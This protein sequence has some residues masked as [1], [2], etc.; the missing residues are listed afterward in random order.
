M[1]NQKIYS[2]EEVSA[3]LKN[4]FNQ[5]EFAASTCANKYL[6]R[7]K[8][9]NFLECSLEQ[10]LNR[11]TGVL[12]DNLPPPSPE[13]L[14]THNLPLSS[15]W[16]DI[17]YNSCNKLKG[18]CP[19][20]SIL[21]GAGDYYSYKSLSN[22]FVIAPPHDSI[23]GIN[24]SAQEEALIMQRRGGVGLDISTL[25]P[26]GLSVTNAAK[27]SSGAAGWMN[28]FS[29][30]CK[31]IGH[32]GRRGALMITLDVKHP[33][34]LL[35][36]QSK[37]DLK[38]CTGANVSVKISD[39]FMKAVKADK[40]F[41]QQFPIDSDKPIFSQ[42]IKARELWA[43]IIKSAHQCA[44]PGLIFWDN[45]I[46]NLPANCYEYFKSSSTNPCSELILSNYDSCR[47]TTICLTN[48]INDPF[49]K[50]PTFDFNKFKFDVRVAMRMMDAVINEEIKCID[51]IIE[52][53]LKDKKECPAPEIYDIELKLWNKIRKAAHDGR[54]TGLGTHALGDCLLKL[55]LKYDTSK[56]LE[57]VNEIYKTLM[58]TAYDESVEMGKEYGIFPAFDWEL[59]KNC[60]FIKRLP[61]NLQNKIK[62]HGRRNISLLTCAPTGTIS[63]L[64]QTS[65]GIEPIFR[66]MYIRRRKINNN[67]IDA[68]VDFIDDLGDRWQE[69]QIF[70]HAVKEYLDKNNIIIPPSV[71]NDTD[72]LKYLP[73]YFITSDRIEWDK[74]IDLQSI[75]QLYIDHSISSTINLPNDVPEDVVAMLY[76]KAWEKQLKGLTVYRDG[77]RTGV[78]ITKEEKPENEESTSPR[79]V[80]VER[81]HSPLRPGVLPCE[82]HITKVKGEDYVVIVGLLNGSVY[83]IFF[84]KYHNNIPHKT[85]SGFIE[86]KGKN[87]YLLNY[88]DKD[89]EHSIDINK[90]FDNDDYASMTRLLSMSLRHGTPLEIVIE[91][92]QKSSSSI[93]GFESAVARILKKYIKLEDIQKSYRNKFGDNIQVKLENGC[94]TIMNLDTGEVTSKCD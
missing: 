82:T 85:F 26:F 66:L 45:A 50:S 58:E 76:E 42:K 1:S 43:E 84:G 86:R 60:D 62:T 35:F 9:T 49:G 89:T 39:E 73:D 56:A 28:Y 40:E 48:Y 22:C 93:T 57:M 46:K 11:V 16:K 34:A 79:P 69:H 81:N 67:D 83:E 6:L 8:D 33:D 47:L 94:I 17:F 68:R 13:W 61:K 5:D 20:G 51:R 18:V 14:I 3:T 90:Y 65:S 2:L 32:Q 38:W 25:R 59:E 74:R 24:L 21:S 80:I 30:V 41:I 37:R 23:P 4:E 92:L 70:H 63:I 53:V 75:T 15:T 88:I 55:K 10:M 64:S 36:A 71:K 54:R 19:Q 91:Q 78:L 12:A 44:E 7:D 87:T 52:K 29:E 72:L 77:C 31:T 27:T